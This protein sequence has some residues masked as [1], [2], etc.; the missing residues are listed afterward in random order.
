MDDGSV[1]NDRTDVAPQGPQAASWV[2]ERWKEADRVLIEERRDYWLN[3]AFYEGDQWVFWNDGQQEVA[4]FP[5]RAGRVHM[6]DNRVLPNLTINHAR[7][8][9]RQLVFEVRPDSADDASIQAAHLS[10]HLLEAQRVTGKWEQIRAT[11]L[12]NADLGGTS[13]V[14]VEWD[15]NAGKIIGLEPEL[16]EMGEPVLDEF[17]QPVEGTRP[18]REGN[19]HLTPLGIT[20]FTLE[21]GTMNWYESRWV[22]T[23]KSLTPNQARE[24]YHLDWTPDADATSG[25]GPLQRKLMSRRTGSVNA[26]MCL[27]YTYYERPGFNTP[28]RHMVVINNRPVVDEEWPFPFDEL[29]GYVFRQ[30][31][32]PKRWTGRTYLNDVRPLQQEYNALKSLVVEHAKM[33]GNARLAIPD[34]SGIQPE[35]LTDTPGEFLYYDGLASSPPRYIDP[36][37]MPRFIKEEMADCRL[38]IDD[39][40]MVHGISRGQA[41]GDRNS[42]L[43][44]TV[45][46][47]KDQT[48][49][50]IFA[51]DQA[52]GWGHI[53]SL[54][55]RLYEANVVEQR[56]AVVS[57]ESRMPMVRAWTGQ[58]IRG[59]TN[60]YV[61]LE[62]VMPFSKAAQQAW[63]L[64]LATQLPNLLPV[65][66]PAVMARMLDLPN[67]D[68]FL[69]VLDPDA[70][71]AQFENSMLAIGNIV[72]PESFDNHG[73]HIAEHNAFRKQPGYQFMP[74]ELRMV[75][76]EHIAAH[77]QMNLEQAANQAQLGPA[78][79]LAQ[80]D[81][82]LGSGV[83]PTF[84]QRQHD[85]QTAMAGMVAP[86]P[87]A[88]GDPAVQPS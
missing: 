79:A 48:P 18:L 1:Q 86:N 66:N 24:H 56:N 29:P 28:G 33:A 5:R 25:T 10:E 32:L 31:K 85:E 75:I 12:F 49:M 37:Q 7:L 35:D 55:L 34:N 82:P 67:A 8:L 44:L 87:N 77:E 83:P 43:A 74:E 80:G 15:P 50:G 2:V 47:E 78:A 13:L 52:E 36:A 39:I 69:Q 46:A 71:K 38:S 64:N 62:N 11:N 23:C 81:E 70:A 19:V 4:Q 65:G 54:C 40:M 72:L 21:P 41:P 3:Y 58:S 9:Q 14:M 59:Q 88:M 53:A 84:A 6:V 45:L 61:P 16:D 27:V 73:K 22:L 20:E 60:T 63:I 51:R 76:D 17:G 57:T 42:G 26:K 30:A 68:A